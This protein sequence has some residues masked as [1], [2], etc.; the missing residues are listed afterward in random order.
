MADFTGK[1]GIGINKPLE[2]LS[3]GEWNRVL[4]AFLLSAEAGFITGHCFP[5]DGGMTIKMIYA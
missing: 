5:V 1:V 2:E 3:L 4:A